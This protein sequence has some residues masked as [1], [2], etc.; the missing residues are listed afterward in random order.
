MK[1]VNVCVC[2]L[3]EDKNYIILK[4]ECIAEKKTSVPTCFNLKKSHINNFFII[5]YNLKNK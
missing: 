5:N 2:V 4:Y 1:M 3:N